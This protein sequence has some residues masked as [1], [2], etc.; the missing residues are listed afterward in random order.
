VTFTVRVDWARNGNFT[1]T[2]DDVT[3]DVRGGMSA[4]YGRDQSTALSPVVAGR[5]SVTL[6]NSTRAYS[7]RNT[8]SPLFGNVKPSRP[9]LI[10][11]T[12]SGTTYAVLRA[13][14]DDSPIDPDVDSKTVAFSLVDYLADFHGVKVT[15]TLYQGLRTGEAIDV[16]LTAA[17][18][19]GGRVLDA[20][21]SLLPWF[22]CNGDDAFDVLQQLLA[23]EGPPSL[24]TVD[25]T[26]AVVFRDRQH[27]IT[28]TAST[29]SQATFT[30]SGSTEPVMG[31]GF[32]YSEPWGNIINDVQIT[33]DERQS[34]GNRSTVWSADATINVDPSSSYVVVVST[35]DPF[36]NAVA[37]ED[38]TDYV[39]VSGSITATALSR[40]SGQ[41]TSI[42][43]TAGAG[44]AQ[45]TGLRLR[46]V[47]VPV[48]RSRV[49]TRSDSTSQTAYG[50][51]SLPSDL[52]P[53]WA[54]YEDVVDLAALFVAT[55]KDPLPQLQAVFTC[56]D[57]Q[58]ARLAAVLTRDLS[59]RVTVVEAETTLNGPFFIE[60]ISHDISN[61]TQHVVAFGLEAVPPTAAGTFRLGTSA[62]GG[63][64]VLGY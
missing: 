29:V 32:R 53:K 38:V 49:V 58:T 10:E 18:W 33:V 24:L 45:I 62:L 6:D 7:P 26:G 4:S 40:T 41:S 47:S 60:S 25:G 54:S 50:V 22:W 28:S 27:R 57:S 46:A 39:V 19:T 30:A 55:R 64:D 34:A 56:Q 42:T 11:R 48:A 5:G 15:T 2:G 8:L 44:G 36:T 35:S 12:I 63:T 9:V 21:S 23:S 51:R 3:L 17:G 31:S 61:V 37:P 13:H 20:G 14:T 52:E 1:D 16:V 59:D 43:L